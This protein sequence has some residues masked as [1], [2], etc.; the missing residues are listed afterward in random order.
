MTL[1]EATAAD[2]DG[3]ATLHAESWR[4]AYRGMFSD[5]YLDGDVLADRLAVWQERLTHPPA[6]QYVVVDDRDG[7]IAGFACAYGADDP[8]WGTLLDN[9]HVRPDG[10]RRGGGTLLLAAIARW[11]LATHPDAGLYLWV[12]A[13]NVS[14]Q[15]FYD[16]WGG[17]NAETK[18]FE[19]PG[20]GSV[21]SYRYVWRDL[22]ALARIDGGE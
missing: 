7:A 10:K 12:L 2:I 22:A 1:R 11:A 19:P 14:A 20:G 9:I 8:R 15:R 13:D 21:E 5:A 18:R 16:R 17:S 4:V 6:N 3:I